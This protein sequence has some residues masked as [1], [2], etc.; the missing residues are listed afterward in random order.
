LIIKDIDSK[1]TILEKVNEIDIN[2]KIYLDMIFLNILKRI[3][4][5]INN[6]KLIRETGFELFQNEWRNFK[7]DFSI[8]IE[9]LI[10]K[11]YL[12]IP[13]NLEDI[14]EGILTHKFHFIFCIY[15]FQVF[16]VLKL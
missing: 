16:E 13:F 14:I 11:P 7:S 5:L 4:Y 6:N 1:K 2:H 10:S 3:K 12:L 9:S 8:V 15:I